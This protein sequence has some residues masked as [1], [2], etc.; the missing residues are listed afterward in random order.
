MPIAVDHEERRAEVVAVAARL[1]AQSGME[2]VSVRDIA[3]AAGCSTAIV[4]HYFHNKR[5]L[6]LLTYNATIEHATLRAQTALAA[7]DGHPKAYLAEIMPLD[8]ER[9]TEWRI[10]LQFWAKAAADPEI[11]EIQKNCVTRTRGNI[12]DILEDEQRKGRIARDVDCALQA[13]RL[14]T[15]IIGMAVQVMYDP[16]DWTVKRQNAFIDAELDAFYRREPARR[17]SAHRIAAE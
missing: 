4:S 5:E 9:W 2:A 1:I 15:S 16:K 7:A 13:R 8:E 3:E 14:L 12:Q 10:W 17:R 11:A 6:L